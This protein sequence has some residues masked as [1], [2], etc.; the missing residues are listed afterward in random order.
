[1]MQPMSS[2]ES[3]FDSLFLGQDMG[4]QMSTLDINGS[5]YNLGGALQEWQEE[6]VLSDTNFSGSVPFLSQ[7]ASQL[8]SLSPGGSTSTGS[9]PFSSQ[10]ASQFS[11]PS[12]GPISTSTPTSSQ[13]ALHLTSLV[14]GQHQKMLLC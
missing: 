14:Q 1:M 2:M 8:S 4:E 11:S 9:A 12:P 10:E 5:S 3:I 6:H 7:E 13:E